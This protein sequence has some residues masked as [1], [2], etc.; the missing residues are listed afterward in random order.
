MSKIV[1]ANTLATGTVVF[2]DRSGHWVESVDQARLFEDAEAAEEGLAIAQR[3]LHRALIVDPFAT[4]ARP[5]AG[6]PPAMTLRDT[7]RAFGPTIKFL[8]TDAKIA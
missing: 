4:D 7:I 5:G 6:G 8:P 3:D 2:L 1:T